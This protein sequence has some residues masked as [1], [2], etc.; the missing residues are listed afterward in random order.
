MQHIW[1]CLSPPKPRKWR[2]VFK[3]LTLLEFL[4]KNGV[5]RCVDEVRDNQFKLRVL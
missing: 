3:A 2:Q 1:E 4:V 5:E